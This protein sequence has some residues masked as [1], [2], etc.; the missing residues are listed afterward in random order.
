MFARAGPPAGNLVNFRSRLTISALQTHELVNRYSVAVLGQ[1]HTGPMV[2]RAR[3]ANLANIL[4]LLRLVLVPIFLLALFCD[5]DNAAAQIL[6]RLGA[7]EREVRA[8]LAELLAES[9][10]ERSA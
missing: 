6:T 5:E 8:A 2:G 1:P 10:R 9:G 4:T 3:I 7:G